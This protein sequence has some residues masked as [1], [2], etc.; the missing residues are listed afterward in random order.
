MRNSYLVIYSALDKTN[1]MKVQPVS[2][3]VKKS[4]LQS[5]AQLAVLYISVK[6]FE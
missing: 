5:W 3:T 4:A 2:V 1:L 6:V